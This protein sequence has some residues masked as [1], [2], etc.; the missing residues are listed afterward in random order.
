MLP[1]LKQR[2]EFLRTAGSGLKA[3]TPGLILQARRRRDGDRPPVDALGPRLGITVSKKVGKAVVRN[4][5]RRR[6]RAV[7]EAILPRHAVPGHDYVLIGRA[8]TPERPFATLTRDLEKS[9]KRLKLFR[10]AETAP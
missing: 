7:A 3:V 2:R 6:L 1:R 8:E 9:L 5:A 10:G 4:R